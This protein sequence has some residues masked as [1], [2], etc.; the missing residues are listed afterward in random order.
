MLGR[1]TSI[2]PSIASS[3]LTSEA[4]NSLLTFQLAHAMGL[5]SSSY[6][7]SEPSRTGTEGVKAQSLKE[8]HKDWELPQAIGYAQSK[9]ISEAVLEEAS[10]VAGV[11][12]AVCRVGQ[13]AGPTSSDGI[14]S[15]QEWLPTLIASSKYLKQIP[16]SLGPMNTIDWIPVDLLGQIVVELLSRSQ[17]WPGSY[18]RRM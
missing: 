16:S 18:D 7:A 5:S 10:R 9:A 3:T 6:L 14:W 8:I 15:K 13:I 17:A 12:S 11:P 4:S 1:W 2:S